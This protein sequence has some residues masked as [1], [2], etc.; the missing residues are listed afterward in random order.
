MTKTTL[1]CG[2][3]LALVIA[4]CAST[5]K[6]TPATAAAG[7]APAGT[8]SATAQAVTK[9]KL[10]CEEEKPLGSNLPQRICMTPEEA[11]AR[12]KAAQD[13]IRNIQSQGAVGP[14]AGGSSSGG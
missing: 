14:G 9:P 1:A 13:R 12:Q 2:L 5:P 8:T 3:A 11:A 10:V 7:A 4:A 6:Q